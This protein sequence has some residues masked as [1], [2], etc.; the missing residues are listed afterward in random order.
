MRW[1]WLTNPIDRSIANA[2]WVGF[3]NWDYFGG[4]LKHSDGHRGDHEGWCRKQTTV[5]NLSSLTVRIG[6]RSEDTSSQSKAALSS[7]RCHLNGF[8]LPLSE[9][10]QL[11]ETSMNRQDDRQERP[12]R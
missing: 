12:K 5:Q 3:L 11:E 4:E 10:L 2:P 8:H 7:V 9:R 6:L 1:K